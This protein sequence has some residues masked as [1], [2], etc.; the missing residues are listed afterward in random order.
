MDEIFQPPDWSSTASTLRSI[1]QGAV[2]IGKALARSLAVLP[3]VAGKQALEVLTLENLWTTALILAIW[4]FASVIGGPVGLAVNGVLIAIA[5]YQIPAFAAELGAAVK[6][7]VVLAANARAESDLDSAAESFA[8]AFSALGIEILQVFVTHRFFVFAKPRLM[9]RFRVPTAIEAEHKRAG[10]KVTEK[11]R[12]E[13]EQ[14][15]TQGARE[16]MGEA[17]ER[18][19][20]A[21]RTAAEV[22]AAAGV[23]PA[24]DL[25]PTVGLIAVGTVAVAGTVA[26]IALLAKADNK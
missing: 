2:R 18:A 17:A 10:S 7:G 19:K 6:D 14:A 13:A 11:A 5:L 12:Q 8:G 4:V 15:K 23:K 24:A 1:Q 16:K 21:A 22:G 25:L 3:S 9:K 26:A 20:A